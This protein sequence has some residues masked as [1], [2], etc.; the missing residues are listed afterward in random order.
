MKSVL[1]GVVGVL[2]MSQALA[3]DVWTW[4]GAEDACWTNPANWTVGGETATV[5]PGVYLDESGAKVGAMDATAEFGTMT[6]VEALTI[7]VDGL[8]DIH[9]MVITADTATKYTFGTSDDQR[10]TLHSTGG[11]FR[12]EAGAKAPVVAAQFGV[13]GYKPASDVKDWNANTTDAGAGKADFSAT[14]PVI[15]NNSSET[16]ELKAYFLN[17]AANYIYHVTVFKGTGNVLLS[18]AAKTGYTTGYNI[19]DLEQNG[20]K[21]TIGFTTPRNNFFYNIQAH[22][23]YAAQLEIA[24]DCVITTYGSAEFL[25]D[26]RSGKGLTV[27]GE[28][29]IKCLAEKRTDGSGGYFDSVMMTP[30]GSSITFKCDLVSEEYGN[31]AHYGNIAFQNYAGNFYL[32]ATNHLRGFVQVVSTEAETCHVKALGCGDVPG[33]LGYGGIKLAGGGKLSYEGP[34]EVT[35]RTL[36][37]TNKAPNAYNKAPSDRVAKGTLVH[38]G[39]GELVWNGPIAAPGVA[40]ATITLDNS[41]TSDLTIGYPIGDDMKVAKTGTG[42]MRLAGACT[43]TGATTVSGGTLAIGPNGSIANTASLTVSGNATITYEGDGTEKTAVLPPFVNTSGNTTIRAQFGTSLE[44]PSLTCTA[45][46]INV[47]P[48]GGSEVKITDPALVG[49]T[50]SWLKYAGLLAKVDADGSVVPTSLQNVIAARGDVVPDKPDESVAVFRKGTG[51][52]DTLEKDAVAMKSLDMYA[53]VAATVAITNGQTLTAGAITVKDGAMSLTFGTVAGEGAVAGG[54]DCLELVNESEFGAI[55]LKSRLSAG[56]TVSS[57]VT[58]N[59]LSGGASSA[60]GLEL[61]VPRGETLIRGDEPFELDMLLVGTN[62]AQT[63]S[64]SVV[65]DGAKDVRLLTNDHV[66]AVGTSYVGDPYV[67]GKSISD[68]ANWSTTDAVYSRMIVRNSKIVQERPSDAIFAGETCKDTLCIGHAGR[69]I[70]E[71]Q[72]GAVITAKVAI[73]CFSQQNTKDPN[74]FVYQTGGTLAAWGYNSKSNPGFVIGRRSGYAYYA[75]EGGLLTVPD[76][77]G[78]TL[79]QYCVGVIEMTGGEFDLGKGPFGINRENSGKGLFRMTGGTATMGAVSIGEASSGGFAHILLE[80]NAK[81][82]CG[83]LTASHSV[84]AGSAQESVLNLNGGIMEA[85]GFQQGQDKDP[86]KPGGERCFTIGYNGGVLKFTKSGRPEA[87]WCDYG[88][89]TSQTVSNML[90]YAGNAIL[91]TGTNDVQTVAAFRSPTGGNVVAVNYTPDGKTY[92]GAPLVRIFGDGKGA[93]AVA[94]YDRTTRKMSGIRLTSAG[95][96][97]TTA[98]ARV[99]S[100]GGGTGQSTS[101]ACTIGE[102]ASG[103]LVKRGTGSLK[104]SGKNTYTGE[105]VVEAGKLILASAT[106]LPSESLLVFNGGTVEATD[107]AFFPSAVKIGFTPEKGKRYSLATFP[108]GAPETA[109]TLIG[110]DPQNWKLRLAGNALKLGPVTGCVLIV[111]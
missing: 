21:V 81:F 22:R 83:N 72:D 96:G 88:Y 66:F 75:L 103:G 76:N 10:F 24:K 33:C 63:V 73:G 26:G 52:A 62:V 93:T 91:D 20:G 17:R 1:F 54:D 98:T 77:Q 11:V 31:G 14:A 107:A 39:S 29:K 67:T 13:L 44:I 106:A 86:T 71:I 23:N 32:S 65:F 85:S 25:K 108:N 53:G 95:S 55:E 59:V 8:Y 7:D 90:V 64:P 19:V 109:P 45:G 105:T 49:T 111:R 61:R 43:Y 42:V 89:T 38:A 100:Y 69:S 70:L 104:L 74:G 80:D 36:Y 51:G 6:S 40:G 57:T 4:T 110:L 41:K 27:F 84:S 87:F 68:S 15:E 37:I 82:S 18:G 79:A 58:S 28:G 101:Y 34:G 9:T 30:T 50:P 35:D 2:A 60:A 46:S 16:L 78:L 3:G 56:R 102:V 92:Y 12:V 99:F 48:S 5:P 47:A 97:Y 94:V